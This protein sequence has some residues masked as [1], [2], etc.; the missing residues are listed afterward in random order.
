MESSPLGTSVS[1]YASENNDNV[2]D[3][4]RHLAAFSTEVDYDLPLE[5]PYKLTID[6]YKERC[7]ELETELVLQHAALVAKNLE[8]ESLK[9]KLSMFTEYYRSL[10]E[11]TIRTRCDEGSPA[12]KIKEEA[13]IQSKGDVLSPSPPLSVLRLALRCA[14]LE[15][16]LNAKQQSKDSC[17]VVLHS[18]D[19][20]TG[21]KYEIYKEQQQK[22]SGVAGPE[23]LALLRS[24]CRQLE[25]ARRVG[26]QLR[27][28]LARKKTVI[29]LTI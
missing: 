28:K 14:E 22:T 25:E 19:T 20:D 12:C 6:L 10:D 9:T 16:A 7:G 11:D 1:T 17:K 13:S 5:T 4:Y 2:E 8:L 27:V 15:A 24:A 29:N 21:N 26:S 18:T 23:L 3:M